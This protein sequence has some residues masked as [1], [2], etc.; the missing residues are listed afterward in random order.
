MTAPRPL[1]ETLLLLLTVVL[2]HSCAGPAP[3]PPVTVVTGEPADF[4]RS[5]YQGLPDDS[6]YRITASALTVQVYRAG[7]LKHLGHNHVISST[8]LGGLIY[9]PKKK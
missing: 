1:S 6:V 9:L 5:R 4:P 2:L 7:S 8:D 3:A